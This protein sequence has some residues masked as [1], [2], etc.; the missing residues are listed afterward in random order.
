MTIIGNPGDGLHPINVK[1]PSE[2][3]RQDLLFANGDYLGRAQYPLLRLVSITDDGYD[4]P[5]LA[6]SFRP[7]FQHLAKTNDNFPIGKFDL[8]YT[9]LFQE[10]YKLAVDSPKAFDH[11]ATGLIEASLLFG[12]AIE[13]ILE[14][15]EYRAQFQKDLVF[16]FR[17]PFFFFAQGP[18][19]IDDGPL[20]GNQF[21][22]EASFAQ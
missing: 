5:F 4:F 19:Q 22:V 17:R 2:H 8:F 13:D 6:A 3:F 12:H 10:A 21:V 16:A 9:M 18:F 1:S 20:E 15:I 14:R 7:C 11:P